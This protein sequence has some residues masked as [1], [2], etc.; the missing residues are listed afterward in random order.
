M[1]YYPNDTSVI[2][3][4]KKRATIASNHKTK[5]IRQPIYLRD[6][7]IVVLIGPKPTEIDFRSFD[8]YEHTYYYAYLRHL[9]ESFRIYSLQFFKR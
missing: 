2:L 4:T 7:R 5:P 1:Y 9:P 3:L 8:V 6:E